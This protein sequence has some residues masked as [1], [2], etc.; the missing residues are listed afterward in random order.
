[1]IIIVEYERKDLDLTF[2]WESNFEINFIWNLNEMK[3][4]NYVLIE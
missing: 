2:I 3:P 4:R 1:M